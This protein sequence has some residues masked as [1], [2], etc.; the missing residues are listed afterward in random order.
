MGR[1]WGKRP[2]DTALSSPLALSHI[3]T[4][5]GLSVEWGG[6]GAPGGARAQMW[7]F[8]MG[9][10]MEWGQKCPCCGWAAWHPPGQ[11]VG[12][13]HCTHGASA[14]LCPWDSHCPMLRL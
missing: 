12:Q 13:Q 9:P 14:L 8:P 7:V 6:V 2:R 4:P 1:M 5:T 10:C 11:H 3:H